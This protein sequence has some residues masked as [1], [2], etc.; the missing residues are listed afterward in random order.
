[1]GTEKAGIDR[2]QFLR[3]AAVTGAVAAWSAPVVKTITGTPAFAQGVS[4]SPKDEFKELS[5]VVVFYSCAETPDQT[6]AVKWGLDSGAAETGDFSI[7]ECGDR[8]GGTCGDPA[9]F[10]FSSDGQTASVCLSEAGVA[11]G[12]SITSGMAKCGSSQ[13][14]SNPCVGGQGGGTCM[15]FSGCGG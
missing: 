10:V 11:A 4:G 2:R 3:R 8:S 15:T 1:M 7:P 6:C 13:S 9:H 5:Y 12:C 14:T